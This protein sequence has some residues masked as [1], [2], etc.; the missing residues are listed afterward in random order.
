MPKVQS[1]APPPQK[2]KK[3]FKDAGRSDPPGKPT[4]SLSSKRNSMTIPAVAGNCTV[5]AGLAGM[6]TQAQGVGGKR[7]MRG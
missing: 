4:V 7:K 2:K 1:G 5:V 6:G 3:M